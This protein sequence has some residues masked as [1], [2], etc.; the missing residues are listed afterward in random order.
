M[1]TTTGIIATT[2]AVLVLSSCTEPQSTTAPL[3]EVFQANAGATGCDLVRDM[4]AAVRDY[5]PHPDRIAAQQK[6]KALGDAC[7]AGSA[8]E[9][10][11]LSSEFLAE[12]EALIVAKRAGSTASGVFLVNALL[13]CMTPS[14]CLAPALQLDL[15]GAMSHS[16]GIFAF[17]GAHDNVMPAVARGWVDFTDLKNQ[18][19]S[20]LWGAETTETWTAANGSTFVLIYGRPG[21]VA[22]GDLN[23]LGIGGLRFDFFR[24]PETKDPKTNG[25]KNDDIVH[26]GVCFAAITELPHDHQTGLSLQPLMQRKQGLLSAYEPTFCPSTQSAPRQASVLAPLAAL[27]QAI[28][29]SGW[30]GRTVNDVRTP[31]IGGSALDFSPFSPVAANASGYLDVQYN[32][33]AAPKVGQSIGD[34]V[35]KA[36]TGAGTP[37]EGVQ[38]SIA[39][40]NNRGEPA[41]AV[42]SGGD[43]TGETREA[44]DYTV[45]FEGL[46]VGKPGGYTLCVSGAKPGFTFAPVCSPLF[47]VK[48]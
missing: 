44:N 12:I 28:L 42:L 32:L 21:I 6:M 15:A 3:D 23:D 40:Y 11:R 37:L 16:A 41:G 8:P 33:P 35:A 7:T 30:F 5:Y 4:T 36:F 22:A 26:V 45:T 38:V 17:R 43:L 48:K 1:R 46:E 25:F 13:K 2:L 9:V 24:Y 47:N 20:A 29:P 34:V 14:L 19:N 39:I 10:T 27:A 31:H 18:Q